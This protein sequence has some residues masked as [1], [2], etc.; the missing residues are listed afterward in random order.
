[1]NN[2]KAGEKTKHFYQK[3]YEYES[4]LP[5]LINRPFIINDQK[6]VFML[7]EA[8]RFLGE[9]N[10][11]SKLIPDIDYFIQMH[12]RSEAVSSSKIEGTKTGMDEILL[13]EEDIDP[14]KRDDWHEVQNYI[15]AMNWAIDNL[16]KLPVSERLIKKTHKV[17]LAGVRGEGKK[18]GKLRKSQNWIGGSTIRTAHFIPPHY[19]EI[20]K[21][22][23]D[24]ENFWH[25]KKLDVPILIRIAIGHY[26]FETIHPFLDGNGRIGRLLITLQ[27]I[28][29]G[30]I[31][32]PVLYYL[33]NY[34]EKNRQS[35][36]D[37]LDTVRQKNN[38]EQWLKFFLEGV[39]ITA[40][41]GKDTFE[42]IIKL[43]EI[44]EAKILK[45]GRK[46]PRARKLLL[47][48]FS[49]PIVDVNKTKRIVDLNYPSAN[50][51]IK[52][53]V[54]LGI[55]EEITGYSRNRLFQMTDY[56]VLFK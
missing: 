4:F 32:K 2:F 28:E 23:S 45:L 31:N 1:M 49:N 24:W 33:S 38:I 14:K 55:L 35:Y 16:D 8:I 41:K 56:V 20:P 44:Y 37:S 52:D 51:L 29:R 46:A 19:K 15:K 25:N 47:Y 30:F 17:L 36:Y 34:F 48:L 7:E 21:L 18:P 22:L 10:A 43:R 26:Q 53:F 40:K 50:K 13:S 11:Y 27:L 3:D 12:V 54:D 9:L 6:I 39:I 5:S 42:N